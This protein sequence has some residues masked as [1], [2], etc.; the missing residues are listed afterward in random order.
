MLQKH[1]LY[2]RRVLHVMSPV[3]WRS[4]KF[5]HHA[6]SNYKVMIKTIKDS[7]NFLP[8]DKPRYLMGVGYPKD[9]IEA[10]RLGV[11][12]FDC[13]IPTRS[14]R[15]GKL[16]TKLGEINI[17]NARHKYDP[18][19]IE[20]SCLCHTCSNGISRS[21]LHHL[22][23]TNEM[24]GTIYCTIHNLFH[25]MELMAD[26]RDAIKNNKFDEVAEQRLNNYKKG[27]IEIYS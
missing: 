14:G 27:D 11:D 1:P 19:P 26:L 6:D 9:I 25:Y 12:M 15:T 2:G 4:T 22:F 21:Y 23:R 7:I 16:F 3:R 13:V 8:I 18:R 17:K 20:F 24:L 10:V 5:L